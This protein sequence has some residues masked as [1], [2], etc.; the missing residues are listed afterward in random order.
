MILK[1]EASFTGEGT[2]IQTHQKCTLQALSTVFP[3]M[4]FLSALGLWSKD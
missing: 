4:L 1:L 3:K 2:E